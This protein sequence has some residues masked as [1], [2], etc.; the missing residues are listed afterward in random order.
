M[1]RLQPFPKLCW[2]FLLCLTVVGDGSECH[3]QWRLLHQPGQNATRWLGQG[4]SAGYHF[5]TPGPRTD[6]YQPYGFHNRYLLSG[7]AQPM[8]EFHQAGSMPLTTSDSHSILQPPIP[9]NNRWDA[10]SGIDDSAA[11]PVGQ[12]RKGSGD[13][14]DQVEKVT[15]RPQ[16]A[17]DQDP[18]RNQRLDQRLPIPP[19]RQP[20]FEFDW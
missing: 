13:G 9:G 14:R 2:G 4:F 19:G 17:V 12:K 3:A 6:Y 7:N 16:P 1:N 8:N 11:I 15:P 18:A 20:P 10:L 5:R